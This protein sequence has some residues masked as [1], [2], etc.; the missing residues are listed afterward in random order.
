MEKKEQ[1]YYKQR[2]KAFEDGEYP[3]VDDAIH[4]GLMA[5]RLSST[6]EVLGAISKDESDYF[7][8]MSGVGTASIIVKAS[9][10]HS[11]KGLDPNMG[12]ELWERAKKSRYERG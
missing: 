5:A 8:A 12:K 3:R 1:S 6:L 2:F 7:M 4:F 11:M 9:E 10:I